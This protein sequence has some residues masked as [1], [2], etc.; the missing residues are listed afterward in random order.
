MRP[1]N[2][3]KKNDHQ[4]KKIFSIIS[5]LLIFVILSALSSCTIS[6]INNFSP[7]KTLIGTNPNQMNGIS[8]TS[9][10]T[11]TL[12][13]FTPTMTLTPSKTISPIY[14]LH[15]TIDATQGPVTVSTVN[16]Q[17]GKY[18]YKNAVVTVWLGNDTDVFAY[19]N[20]D[21]LNK[22]GISNSDVKIEMATG[23]LSNYVLYPIN[24]AYYYQDKNTVDYDSCLVHFPVTGFTHIDYDSQGDNFLMGKPY[25]VL[26]NEGRIA[27]VS[28]VKDSIKFNADFSQVLSVNVTVYN[29][30][31]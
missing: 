6:Q 16:S 9:T 8:Q 15:I 12:D 7:T 22:N 13:N 5:I 31:D 1:F 3:I 25:C 19:L 2:D 14:D 18:L 11:P 23:D 17:E 20:L 10:Q 29:K 21:D 24:N 27:I 4:D 28:F 26:T 30:Q